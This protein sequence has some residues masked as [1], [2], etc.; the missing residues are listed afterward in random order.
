VDMRIRLAAPTGKAAARMMDAIREAKPYIKTSDAI[1]QRIPEE[2]TTL[3][4]LLGFSPRGYRHHQ[5]NPILLDC[6]VIDEASMVD[7]PMMARVLDALPPQ[8]RIILLGDRDQLSSVDAGNV[9]GDITG[10]GNMLAYS[11][12]MAKTL[13]HDTDTD[14][15]HIPQQAEAVCIQDGI[16]LLRKSYRFS[17]AIAALAQ[18]INQGNA[19][20]VLTILHEPSDILHWNAEGEL[21]AMLEMAAE[22]YKKYLSCDDV[23]K[24]LESF[25]SCRVLCAVRQGNEGVEAINRE[26]QQRLLGDME[27]GK[28]VHGMPIMIRNNHYDLGLFN[29]DTGL[30]WKLDGRLQ[31]C[32]FDV[33]GEVRFF[34]MHSLPHYEPCWAMTVHKSQ[35]SE[36]EHVFLILPSQEGEH[37]V[38]SRELFYTAI[39]RSKKAF[40]LHGRA[41]TIVA[42]V[43][44]RVQRN[45]GL[46]NRLGW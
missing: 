25:E 31:A 2:A 4:R 45:T 46:A 18:H 33:S 22:Q 29:G 19:Q 42:A 23:Q 30:I 10:H 13:A 7:L 11:P 32:F 24:A 26:M 38:L 27:A 36:F 16:A 21:N 6:L 17:G 15:K 41:E 39:T 37:H 43:K 28:A 12:N 9:L 8:A 40:Y 44:H 20:K 1:R 34:P 5:G 3:H 14:I 35:G